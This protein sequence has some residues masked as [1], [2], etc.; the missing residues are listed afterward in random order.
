MS[1]LVGLSGA[2]TR[3]GLST[4][5]LLKL[6]SMIRVG[7]LTIILP[8][9][10]T[11]KFVGHKD[12]DK[13]K[14][15]CILR[16]NRVARRFLVRG[17]L[18]FCESYLGGDWESPDLTALFLLGAVNEQAFHSLING[19]RLWRWVEGQL[20][21]GKRNTKRG[22][23][24]NIAHHYDLGNKFYSEWLDPSMTYS[25]ALYD[26]STKDPDLFDA[27]Q[28]KYR[29]LLD[30]LN[31]K[32]GEHIL[33]IGCG[34]GGFAEFVGKHTDCKLTGLTI[35]QEQY[36]FAVARIQKARLNDRV[37]IKL[38]DYRDCGGEYD[39]IASIEMFEAVGQDYW[40]HFFDAVNARLRNGGRAA[41]QVISIEERLF[42]IYQ[43]GADYIQ[44]YIF[45]GGV[46]PTLRHLRDEVKRANLV[47]VHDH[48]FG[49]DYARTLHMWRERFHENWPQIA[50]MGF[51]DR[52]RRMWEQYLSYCEAGFKAG[53][54]NVHQFSFAKV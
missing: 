52:F 20:N 7:E 9:G 32:S 35:S 38:C 3:T 39:H 50:P 42:D 41:M 37:T 22:S 29:R 28:N 13:Y 34:W 5:I 44:K 25:A 6:A 51:D 23:R 15:T 27:Q 19:S 18:G 26:G 2:Q 45:P 36:D 1:L 17:V 49:Q 16:T 24:R 14:A 54:I 53:T 40:P 43:R 12:A 46:L 31:P 11:R 33:E 47:W 8:N 10:E 21:I 30:L 48:A 4:H